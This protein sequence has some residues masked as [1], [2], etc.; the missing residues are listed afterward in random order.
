MVERLSPSVS[1]EEDG[2]LKPRATVADDGWLV[3]YSDYKALECKL[4]RLTNDK[5]RPL[6]C[7]AHAWSSEED[8]PFCNA[9]ELR[10][11]LLVSQKLEG[12]LVE[13]VAA[14]ESR[15]HSLAA[16]A[17]AIE[18]AAKLGLGSNQL[19]HTKAAL[20]KIVEVCEGRINPISGDVIGWAIEKPSSTVTSSHVHIFKPSGLL[21]GEQ[22]CACGAYNYPTVVERQ[23]GK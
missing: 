12:Q 6:T 15:L 5:L 14:A 23:D 16:A 2:V 20:Q 8:C 22:V 7:S 11:A 4:D 17:D 19:T 10:E 1:I 21:N 9:A 3:S 13:R 18:V